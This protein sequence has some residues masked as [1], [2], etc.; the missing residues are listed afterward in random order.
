MHLPGWLYRPFRPKFYQRTYHHQPEYDFR[1]LLHGKL[2]KAILLLLIERNLRKHWL[3]SSS[4]LLPAVQASMALLSLA[5]P[6]ITA[7][8]LQNLSLIYSQPLSSPVPL[9]VLFHWSAVYPVYDIISSGRCHLSSDNPC[10]DQWFQSCGRIFHAGSRFP[11]EQSNKLSNSGYDSCYAPDHAFQLDLE[12]LYPSVGV[13]SQQKP[14]E[15]DCS[16]APEFD[17]INPYGTLH[18]ISYKFINEWIRGI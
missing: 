18:A 5:W 4:F 8:W 7:L 12:Q 10:D 11:Y 13:L 3:P 17:T 15:Y 16:G 14:T 9:A 6:V 2:S 1:T